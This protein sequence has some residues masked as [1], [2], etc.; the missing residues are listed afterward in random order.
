MN[1]TIGR[2]LEPAFAATVT[3]V[4]AAAGRQFGQQHALGEEGRW[5]NDSRWCSRSRNR[6]EDVVRRQEVILSHEATS[7]LV[8]QSLQLVTQIFTHVLV[9]EQQRRHVLQLVP[10]LGNPGFQVNRLSVNL[11]QFFLKTIT[12]DR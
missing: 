8:L 11:R 10:C 4:L 9:L 3:R 2:L 6:A 7:P 12:H 1:V 5:R